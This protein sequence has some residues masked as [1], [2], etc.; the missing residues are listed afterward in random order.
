MHD[1]EHERLD[2]RRRVDEKPTHQSQESGN[3]WADR[4]R[5]LAN[6]PPVLKILWESGP[7]VVTWGLVLQGNLRSDT[8]G[9][10]E[11]SGVDCAGRGA[12]DP[13]PGDTA[14]LLVHGGPGESRWRC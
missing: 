11:S 5:A 2:N 3:A 6:I 1:P 8:V 12:G 7:Q 14:P 9:P 4:L 10:R 13:A